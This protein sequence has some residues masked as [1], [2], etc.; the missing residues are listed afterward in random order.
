M[1]QV[2]R[3]RNLIQQSC[4]VKHRMSRYKMNPY[5]ISGQKSVPIQFQLP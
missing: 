1:V 4:R 5:P 3:G 2:S